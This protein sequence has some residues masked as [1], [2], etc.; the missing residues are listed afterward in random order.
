MGIHYREG[1]DRLQALIDWVEDLWRQIIERYEKI[2][3]SRSE[4]YL[5]C[6]IVLHVGHTS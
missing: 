6:L 1:G 3:H 5:Y 4:N 2:P